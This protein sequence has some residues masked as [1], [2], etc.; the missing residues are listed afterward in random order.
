MAQDWDL[1]DAS[2]SLSASREMLIEALEALLSCFSGE[3][4]PGPSIRVPGML[5]FKPSLDKLYIRDAAD[6][7]WVDLT[8]G[9][10]GETN[11]ASNG[12]AGGV[13]VY[14]SKSG[15]DLIFRNII[16]GNGTIDVSLDAGNKEVE[17]K[18]PV[19]GITSSELAD[20]SVG[21]AEMVHVPQ[22][23][24]L[25]RTTAGTGAWET[26]VVA[27]N[28]AAILAAA[29]YAA[30]RALLSLGTMALQAASAVAITGGAITGTTIDG[31]SIK[32]YVDNLAAG[33]KWKQ[34]VIAA[35]TA[36]VTLAS[37]LENGDTLDGVVLTTGD[38]ILVKDQAAG[39]ENGIYVVA[40]SGAPAR[41]S[42]ADAGVELVGAS[43]MVEQG[44]VNADKVFVCTN[45]AITLGST[46]VV[47]V[48]FNVSIS[49][50]LAAANNLSD[51]LNAGTARTNLGLG[52][53]A[54]LASVATANLDAGAVTLAKMAQVAQYKLM[55]R[56]TTG[57]GDWEATTI[58]ANIAAILTAA[59]YAA[60]RTLLGSGTNK[61]QITAVIG[62]GGEVPV[63]PV[64]AAVRVP[65]TGTIT[66]AIAASFSVDGTA[67]SGS[68]EI[69]VWKAAYASYPPV[70]GGKISSSAPITITVAT[71]SEDATLT[72][73][74]LGV[75]VGDWL[76]FKL[77]SI[78]GIKQVIV[79]LEITE[80]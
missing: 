6:A 76:I 71:K 26:S 16:A 1:P 4:A 77:N 32:S 78:S 27:A 41:A 52:A 61:R 58:A 44:T 5:W 35:T 14:D 18:V 11:T 8:A 13:G 28:V 30:I 75:T 43:V 59:D 22:Y 15:V 48:N 66:K 33:L 36:A 2:D 51:L 79:N 34:T 54:V 25:I 19:G 21:L 24:I 7:N 42:D 70:V 20:Q 53:L 31:V 55:F 69:E 73:W 67:V 56:T 64:Y 29:D 74:T 40:A 45:N 38:R 39:A 62:G 47:F 63:A 50:A 23:S 57:T 49:G 9:G 17:I 46:A 60:V 65:Y 10:G 3:T 80:S 37:D 72:G 68:A 12:G